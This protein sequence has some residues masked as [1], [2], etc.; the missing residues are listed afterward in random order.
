[1][2]VAKRNP[3]C[4]FVIT[5]KAEGFTKLGVKD[6]KT[7]NLHFTGYLTDGEVKSLMSECRAF[8]H[9]AIY[10]GFG[11]PPLEALS[12]GARLILSTATCL[13]EIYED[14]AYYIDPYNYDVNLEDMLAKPIGDRQRILEKFSW[15][16]DARKLLDILRNNT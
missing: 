3:G 2:E 10:E 5:G 16:A 11:I 1:M 14:S 9:P 13:P 7:D 12:C 15:D 4:Q 8:I 6:L